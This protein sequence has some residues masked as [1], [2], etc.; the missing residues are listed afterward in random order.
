[1]KNMKAKKFGILLSALLLAAVAIVPCVSAYQA[2]S[3]GIDYADA[4]DTT[5]VAATAASELSSMGYS[6]TAYTPYPT[7]T[8]ART[9]M[10]SDN[11]FFF[12]GHGTSGGIEFYDTF[13]TAKN[14]GIY[15]NYLEGSNGELQDIVLAVFMSCNSAVSHSVYGNLPNQAYS[16]GVD[17]SIAWTSD[18]HSTASSIWSDRFW[19]WLNQGCSVKIASQRATSDVKAVVPPVID[20][21]PNYGGMTNWLC[22]A[23]DTCA[24]TIKPARAG[25]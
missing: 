3:Y 21:I 11:V 1:M 6:S 15:T 12:D 22:K 9:Q 24:H 2:S 14:T 8:A 17:M 10:N 7:V 25:Y 4:L 18:I 23:S 16:E 20:G 5:T 13:M 19:Y